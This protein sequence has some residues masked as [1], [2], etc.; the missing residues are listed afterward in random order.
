[1]LRI[2]SLHRAAQRTLEVVK[3]RGRDYQ[4]GRRAQM[5]RP[6]FRIV[7]GRDVEVY[8]SRSDASRRGA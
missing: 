7:N 3:S 2:E 8:P 4:M 6:A 5:G 1:L